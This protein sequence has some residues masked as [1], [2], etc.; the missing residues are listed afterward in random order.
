VASPLADPALSTPSPTS[1]SSAEQTKLPWTGF[2][3]TLA[4]S[5]MLLLSFS[6]PSEDAVELE[7]QETAK[8]DQPADF[9]SFAGLYTSAIELPLERWTWQAELLASTSAVS[10]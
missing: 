2:S 6:A 3:L 1:F 10:K 9:G 8:T 4:V 5:W 7:D